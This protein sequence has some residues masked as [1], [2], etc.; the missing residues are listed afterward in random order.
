MLDHTTMQNL[1]LSLGGLFWADLERHHPGIRSLQLAPEVAAGWKQRA[2]TKTRT[3]TDTNGQTSQLRV[4]RGSGPDTLATVRAF[5]LDIAQWAMEDPA[6][7]GPLAVPCPVRAEDL[8]RQKTIRARKSRMD[9]RTRE[10][11]PVLPVLMAHV[12]AARTATAADLQAAQA[13][14][15][16]AVFPAGAGTLRRSELGS[17]GAVRV[18]ADDPDTGKRRNL[19]S[20][21]ARSG[22]GRRFKRCGIPGSVSR[23]LPSCP[24]TA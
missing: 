13:V 15:P 16:G 17:D 2:M 18:W 11:L 24:T 19:T 21:T 7:W 23:N 8:A 12:H 4:P 6:R 9:Q 20:E 3:I 5:Y 10:R 22:P 1:A 14:P